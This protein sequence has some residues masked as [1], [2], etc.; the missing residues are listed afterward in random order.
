MTSIKESFKSAWN[1]IWS[2]LKGILNNIIGGT[3]KMINGLIKAIN[4]MVT[5][6]NKLSFTAPDWVP[7]I[8]G[9]KFG[10]DLKKVNQVSLPRLAQ[11]GYV[12]ANQPQPVIVGDNKTQGEIISPEGKMSS[13]MLDALETFFSR[14]QQSGYRASTADGVGDIVIPIYLDGSLLDEVIV[15]AQ[16]RRNIRSG[17]R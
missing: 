17:G 10:F 4:G 1:N 15:S 7:G 8:G 3:E 13:V 16:Q 11:G 6:L 9:K 5:A 14:L 12:K 2:F